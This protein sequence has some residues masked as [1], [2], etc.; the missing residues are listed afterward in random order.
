MGSK[1]RVL[2]IIPGFGGGISSHVRNIINGINKDEVTIDVAGF[3]PYPDEF[4]AE[5]NNKGGKTFTLD[6]VRIHNLGKCIKQFREIVISGNYDAIHMHLADVQA[7]YFSILTSTCGIKRKIVHAH[8]ADQ[9]GSEK[10]LFK[11]RKKINQILTVSSATDLASCSKLSSEFRFGKKYVDENRVMHIPNSINATNYFEKISEDEIAK[12]REEFK[13]KEEQLIIG[14]VGFFGY[15]KNH[16]F[17]F[18]IARRLKERGVDF[19]WL[20]IGTGYNFDEYVHL[21]EIM[22]LGDCV[23][24]LGR[25]NDVCALY[26][27]MNVSVLASFFEGLPTVTIE[28]QAAGTATVISDSISDETD[29]GLNMIKRVSLNDD[30]D[31]WSDAIL[32]MSKIK[33]PEAEERKRNIEK[34]AFTTLTAAKLYTKFLKKEIMTYNLGTEIE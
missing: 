22:G 25:R 17:M 21:A 34:R 3:T 7:V 24:F 27:I 31:T 6:N 13:I 14:H 16:P 2:H 30:V 32:E 29:M 1:I 4:I 12:Y 8:I 20:F 19:V 33:V 23:R 5:V 15:Q 18:K 9:Q 26:K 10:A 11:I 28:T